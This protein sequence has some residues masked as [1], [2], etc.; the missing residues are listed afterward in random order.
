MNKKTMSENKQLLLFIAIAYGIAWIG[1]GIMILLY[2]LNVLPENG[3]AVHYILIAALAGFAPTYAAFIVKFISGVRIKDMLRSDGFFSGKRKTLIL[4]FVFFASVIALNAVL[5]TK[6]EWPWYITPVVFIV[7]IFGGGLEEVGW[8]SIMQPVLFKKLP[9]F[10]A[11]LVQGL[12]WALWHLPLWFV[13]NTSQSTMSF[14]AFTIYSVVICLAISVLYEATGS[15]L[16]CICLHAWCNTCQGI[17]A[18]GYLQKTPDVKTLLTFGCCCIA[19]II[20]Y[21]LTAF[22]QRVHQAS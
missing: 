18:Y 20:I 4:L 8:R 21:F 12:M 13:K 14:P 5:E 9:F 15:V 19:S 2:S 10:I 16:A 1:E 3:G 11:V 22:R 17:F 6:N 7:M